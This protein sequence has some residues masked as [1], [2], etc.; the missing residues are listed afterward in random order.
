MSSTSNQDVVVNDFDTIDYFT[1]Q[2]LIADP[3]PYFEHL[4]AKC[5]VTHLPHHGVVAVTGQDEALEVFRDK[6]TFSSCNS[7]SGPFPGLPVKPEGDD[8]S[9]LIEQYRD[10]L[11]MSD[12]VVALDPPTH[13]EQRALI[14]RLLTPKRVKENEA[15]MWRLAD[16]Q[17]D[18]F[19]GS[20]KFEVLGDYARPFTALVIADL[21]G[22]P[23][24]DHRDF[25]T[26]LATQHSPAGLGEAVRPRD[27]LAFL[28]ERFT[29]Y[30]EDRRR[31]P[32]SDVLTKLATATYPDG[33][34]PD[35]GVVVR[36]ATFLFGAGQDTT[37]R[38]IGSALRILAERPD[39][40]Q[41]LRDDRARIPDFIDEVLRLESP[42]KCG[43]RM[44]RV[45]TSLAG[46]DIPAG[47][48]VAMMLA[49]ANRDPR[50]FDEPQELNLDRA[51]VREHFAFGRGIHACPGGPLAR[52]EAQVTLERIFD[53]MVDIRTSESEH[54]PADARR[55]QF[56]PTYTGRGVQALH[57]EFT[58]IEYRRNDND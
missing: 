47:A 22:V 21:L 17:I 18:E 43:F 2:S 29:A 34:T 53:R 42:V 7:V 1:D 49:A 41:L 6:A 30:V 52:V 32:R 23:D 46:V 9:D 40:Q 5:P 57:L 13:T 51:N 56:A 27:P 33:G 10:Q 8:I 48:T 35:V 26:F 3:Y 36:M 25:R 16:N 14:M 39:L 37:A 11:P 55:Y 24:E 4:R 54:G 45:T 44:A 50:R 19:I 12:Y 31:K 38:L 58:P 15:F 28:T 20:G